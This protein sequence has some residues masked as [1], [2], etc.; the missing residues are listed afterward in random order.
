MSEYLIRLHSL[1][2]HLKLEG[3]WAFAA[4]IERMILEERDSL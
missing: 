3:A 4:I 2:V 1:A